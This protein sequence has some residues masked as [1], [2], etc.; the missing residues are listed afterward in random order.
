MTTNITDIKSGA[1][2]IFSHDSGYTLRGYSLSKLKE[3]LRNHPLLT[4]RETEE[5][6]SFFRESSSSN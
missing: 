5:F 3:L 1:R 2:C 4:A 6:K